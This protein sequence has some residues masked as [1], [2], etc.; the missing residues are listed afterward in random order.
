MLSLKD[1][2]LLNS[3]GIK[4]GEFNLTQDEINDI[5]RELGGEYYYNNDPDQEVVEYW[6]NILASSK[7]LL[8][9]M[10]ESQHGVGAHLT[11]ILEREGIWYLFD[12]DH[13]SCNGFD[14]KSLASFEVLDK[15]YDFSRFLDKTD[16]EDNADIDQ[17][18]K[19]VK[20]YYFSLRN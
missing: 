7:V 16:V 4:I 9:Y 18:R 12:G 8:Y 10:A 3:E 2:V 1:R 11:L 5:S 14:T 19:I 6:Q 20:D 15:S 17:I 13:C